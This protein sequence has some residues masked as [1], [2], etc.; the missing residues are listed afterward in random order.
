MRFRFLALLLLW[1]AVAIF[2]LGLGRYSLTPSE[3]MATLFYGSSDVAN[4]VI[5]DIRLPRILLASLC[6]GVLGLVGISL[7]GVFKNPL[8][9]P[10]IVGVSTAAAFGGALAI[11]FGLGGYGITAAAFGFGVLAL[12]ILYLIATYTKGSD[13]FSLVLA[14][15]VINGVFAALISLV[16]YLSD[17]EEVLPNIIYW[18]LGSF[19]G[20]DA[21]KLWLMVIITLP[22]GGALVLM[23]YR[24][25]LLSLSE[26]D[27]RTM[28]INATLLQGVILLLCTLLI[29][30]QVSISGNIGWVGLVVPHITRLIVGADHTRSVPAS[31]VFGAIFM[32]VVDD[33]ARA[34]A[35]TEIPL[36]ILNALIGSP[37]FALLLKRSI[38]AKSA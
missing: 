24:L 22:C 34:V 10:H 27:L 14:G 15:I 5:Y 11:L 32:L 17:S 30:A 21:S 33:V 8:V 19:V 23:R 38:G 7:Q 37:I 18:L 12:F 36:G 2:S 31:F 28:G 20:A 9:G 13:I 1:L 35:S 26:Q 3:L 16:Q 4:S 6:G 25:N 29:A